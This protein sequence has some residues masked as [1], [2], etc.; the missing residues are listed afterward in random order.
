VAGSLV[1][2]LWLIA[3]AARR[4]GRAGRAASRLTARLP[5]L[6]AALAAEGGPHALVAAH[7]SVVTAQA[8]LASRRA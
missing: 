4:G 2:R 5:I 3:G 1:S 8:G 6:G 7:G